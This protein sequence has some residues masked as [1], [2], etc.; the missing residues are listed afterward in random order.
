MSPYKSMYTQCL[1]TKVCT[2]NVSLQ[3]YVHTMS[4]YKSMYTQCLP[5]KVCTHNVPLQKYVHTMSPYKS[6][7]YQHIQICTLSCAVSQII[8]FSMY[9]HIPSRYNYD[10]GILSVEAVDNIH[11]NLCHTSTSIQCKENEQSSQRYT[12]Y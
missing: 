6:V 9:P 5:T 4:P 7:D 2:H 11:M 10:H 8:S 3:K 12:E 1:P